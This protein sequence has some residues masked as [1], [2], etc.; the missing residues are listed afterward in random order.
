M[1]FTLYASCAF[2][3]LATTIS[4][5]GAVL[6]EDRPRPRGRGLS[7]RGLDVVHDKKGKCGK[8]KDG[9]TFTETDAV[10]GE[11]LSCV[12]DCNGD[13]RYVPNTETCTDDEVTIEP[14]DPVLPMLT[15]VTSVK[16][17]CKKN[18]NCSKQEAICPTNYVATGGGLRNSGT[19]NPLLT[20]RDLGPDKDL[21][22]WVFRG[23]N[24]NTNDDWVG[25]VYVICILGTKVNS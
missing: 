21:E 3:L 23:K 9:P 7:R 13:V 25:K 22:K 2:F 11:F 8:D 10:G 4:V 18:S 24:V 1:R 20:I 12:D 14:T 19:G 6:V 16:F 5:T 15:V 17:T